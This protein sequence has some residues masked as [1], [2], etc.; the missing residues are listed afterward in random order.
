L[1]LENRIASTWIT[2]NSQSERKPGPK[3]PG[4]FVPSWLNQG[5]HR[6][7]S[8]NIPAAARASD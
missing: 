6:I 2:G 1:S 4:F 7:P 3:R 8:L 5:A